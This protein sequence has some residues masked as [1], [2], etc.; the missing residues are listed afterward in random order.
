MAFVYIYIC[1]HCILRSVL[2]PLQNSSNISES[3]KYQRLPGPPVVLWKGCKTPQA[4]NTPRKHDKKSAIFLGA[5]ARRWQDA[6]ALLREMF[7]GPVCQ[8]ASLQFFTCI[9]ISMF[10]LLCSW[11][12][13]KKSMMSHSIDWVGE[14]SMCSM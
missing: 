4:K 2:V 3:N 10:V 6:L 12:F 13:T 5:A 14:Y 7:G 11:S 1:I 9:M 8:Y